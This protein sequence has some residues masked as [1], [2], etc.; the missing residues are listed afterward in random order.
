LSSV[1][2]FECQ[3]EGAEVV[4]K[5]TLRLMDLGDCLSSVEMWLKKPSPGLT[6]Y[7]LRLPR[8]K[9]RILVEFITGHYSSNKHLHNMCL[10]D[11]PICIACG[12]EDESAFHLVCNCPSLISL[13]MRTFSK[14]ILSVEEYEGASVSTL[15]QFALAS[16]RFFVTP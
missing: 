8:S 6:R 1:G 14:P 5:I 15:L 13:R 16:G 4:T 3:A 10:I 2:T 11:E 7:L 9:L 12:M